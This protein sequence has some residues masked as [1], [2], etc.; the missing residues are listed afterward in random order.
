[1]DFQQTPAHGRRFEGVA[2]KL[3]VGELFQYHYHVQG[4]CSASPFSAVLGW[5]SCDH[6][7]AC[8]YKLIVVVD[9]KLR[10]VFVNDKNIDYDKNKR[11]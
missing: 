8:N 9:W 10:D 7:R 1:L 4:P 5:L 2:G 6:S 3:T 11:A